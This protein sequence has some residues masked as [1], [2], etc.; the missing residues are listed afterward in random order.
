MKDGE[1]TSSAELLE[2]IIAVMNFLSFFVF[3]ITGI[4]KHIIKN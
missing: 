3:A 1:D 4:Y 2:F